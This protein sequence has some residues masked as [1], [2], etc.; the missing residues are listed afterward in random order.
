MRR[1]ACARP[2]PARLDEA[3]APPAVR[4]ARVGLGAAGAV[5]VRGLPRAVERGGAED[6]YLQVFTIESNGTSSVQKFGYRLTRSRWR[7][8]A[9]VANVSSISV[10]TV[11]NPTTLGFAAAIAMVSVGIGAL[12]A[13]SGGGLA[14]FFPTVIIGIITSLAALF[15]AKTRALA[16]N[17]QGKEYIAV[18]N[19]ASDG[20]IENFVRATRE[21]SAAAR[22]RATERQERPAAVEKPASIKQKIEELADLRKNGLISEEE[23]NRLRQSVIEKY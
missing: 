6:A 23:F 8:K 9:D 21:V 13:I 4:R 15:N 5:P 11:T 7:T 18:V 10:R 17:V 22:K 14:A 2:R 1:G 20:E 12:A 16:I 19:E 3:P